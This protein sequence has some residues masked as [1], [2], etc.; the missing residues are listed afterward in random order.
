MSFL[1]I[2][3]KF[4]ELLFLNVLPTTVTTPPLPPSTLIRLATW[5]VVFF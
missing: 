4:D 3:L 1:V 2:V 5:W